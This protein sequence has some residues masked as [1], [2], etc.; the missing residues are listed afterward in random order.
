MH[1]P[2]F[3]DMTFAN[4][5]INIVHQNGYGLEFKALNALKEVK[6]RCLGDVISVSEDW[7][8]ARENCEYA[9]Q[10]KNNFDWTYTTFYTG[11]LVSAAKQSEIK[12]EQ[13][14]ESI[15]LDKLR[16]QEEILF[17][18][19]IDLFEDELADNGIAKLTLKIVSFKFRFRKEYPL[20]LIIYYLLC[21]V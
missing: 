3:P 17:F 2:H 20:K 13:T 9:K 21:S 12:I 1:L 4:N 14:N 15:N 7:L 11:H 19:E 8:K 6:D 10:V 18:D 5:L 16:V